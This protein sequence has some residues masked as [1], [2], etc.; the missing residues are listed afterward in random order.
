MNSVTFKG[1]AVTLAGN[2]LKVGDDAPQV[3][4][5]AKDLSDIIIGAKDKTQILLSVPSL[6]T[7][8]CASEARKFNEKIASYKGAEVIIISEDLP[9]AM[10]RFC[11]TEGINGLQTA[12]DFV[13]KE[14]G[15][16]YGVL[17]ADGALKGLLARAVFVVQNG[18]I[19]YK[20][21]VS[22]ITEMPNAE[23]L[24]EFFRGR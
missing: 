7:P 23:S 16:K 17:M 12:S 15:E 24:D 4:L 18:K 8:V 1:N 19:A 14:F 5:K 6:D 21:L 2:A 22:E 20:E 10:G 11:A 9:F 13:S 3:V